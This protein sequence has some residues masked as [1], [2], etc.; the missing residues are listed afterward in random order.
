MKILVALKREADRGVE[1]DR[2]GGGASGEE[3]DNTQ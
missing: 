1:R 2:L 3:R